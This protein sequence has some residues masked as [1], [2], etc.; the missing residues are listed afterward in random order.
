MSLFIDCITINVI[1]LD[2]DAL[3]N[4]QSKDKARNILLSVHNIN[5]L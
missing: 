1:E 5:L 2:D 3:R 4:V